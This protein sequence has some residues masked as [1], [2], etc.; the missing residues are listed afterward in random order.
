ML[1]L[2]AAP[3]ESARRYVSKDVALQVWTHPTHGQG[4]ALSS[5]PTVMC[6][7]SPHRRLVLA[8][9][10]NA[11]SDGSVLVRPPLRPHGIIIVRLHHCGRGRSLGRGLLAP[12]RTC[13][14]PAAASAAAAAQS[15]AAA[16]ASAAAVITLAQAV[17]GRH[18]MSSCA[19]GWVTLD[20][21]HRKAPRPP[22]STK[23]QRG[24][25]QPVEAPSVS[26]RKL[27]L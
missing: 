9:D 14:R 3:L 15:S 21:S 11:S 24:A 12:R 20:A 26:W 5:W 27:S 23:A 7:P 2:G 25:V 8:Y 1:P 10:S 13:S 17:G 4:F 19:A 16:A 22:G 6:T 18:V